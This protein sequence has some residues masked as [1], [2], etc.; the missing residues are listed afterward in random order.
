MIAIVN[1]L[2][3]VPNNIINEFAIP[4]IY[5]Q[6]SDLN[7]KEKVLT[8]KLYIRINMLLVFLISMTSTLI[9]YLWGKQIIIL[10][11]NDSYTLYWSLLPL[12]C[13]GSGLFLTGQA[14][15]VLGLALNKPDKY[16][17]PKISIGIFSVV[18]NIILI[19]QFGLSGIAYTII[20]IGFIYVLYI[21]LVNKIIL[22]SR[23]VGI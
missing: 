12:I 14:Q 18:L 20:I 17:L 15:T 13:L 10:I 19:N 9:T 5:Q 23:S 22:S 7:N 16:I 21:A 2:V 11:S 4:I 1:A 8:G 3:V 6:F